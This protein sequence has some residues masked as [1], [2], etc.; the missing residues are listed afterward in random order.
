[1]SYSVAAAAAAVG[2]SKTAVLRAIQAGL[3]SGSKNEINEWRV[4]PAELKQLARLCRVDANKVS[5]ARSRPWL[6][7]TQVK[8]LAGLTASDQK[9]QQAARMHWWRRV[10]SP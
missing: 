3:I 8:R 5:T 10:T 9:M 2:L 7:D 1:V 6:S 4:N